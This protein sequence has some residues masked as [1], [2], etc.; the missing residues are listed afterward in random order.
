[1]CT[2]RSHSRWRVAARHC[3]PCHGAT[4]TWWTRPLMLTHWQD[5]SDRVAQPSSSYRGHYRQMVYHHGPKVLPHLLRPTVG[6]EPLSPRLRPLCPIHEECRLRCHPCLSGTATGCAN[7]TWKEER[8]FLSQVVSL[9]GRQHGIGQQARW[10]HVHS[11]LCQLGMW[12]VYVRRVD[13][14]D[15]AFSLSSHRHSHVRLIFSFRF[16]TVFLTNNFFIPEI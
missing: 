6:Y 7:D 2:R 10:E 9:E 8:L 15:F 16:I 13:P 3:I 1:M 11:F 5:V 4:V 14:L 12:D